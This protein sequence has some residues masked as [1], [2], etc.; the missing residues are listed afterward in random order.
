MHMWYPVVE[1]P[2][3]KHI[4]VEEYRLRGQHFTRSIIIPPGG[5]R[6]EEIHTLNKQTV[7]NAVAWRVMVN[8]ARDE[9]R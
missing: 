3:G 6:C 2:G 9:E 5:G 1:T 7:V 8:E 4:V